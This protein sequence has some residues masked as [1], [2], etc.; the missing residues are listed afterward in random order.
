MSVKKIKKNTPHN[1]NFLN[2][3]QKRFSK[4]FFKNI[5]IDEP[6]EICG[7]YILLRHCNYT[8]PHNDFPYNSGYPDLQC[9]LSSR[10]G[11]NLSDAEYIFNT[12]K[13][14]YLISVEQENP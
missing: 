12:S 14:Y 11:E 10:I 3:E 4:D 9:M 2:F 5:S 7:W 8:R 1:L 6:R 13:K